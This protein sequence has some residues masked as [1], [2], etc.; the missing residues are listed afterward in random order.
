MYKKDRLNLILDILGKSKKISMKELRELTKFTDSTLRRDVIS[1]ENENKIQH[2]YGQVELVKARNVEFP[3][4]FRKQ[5][6]ETQ[7][8]AM[9]KIAQDFL[10]D[11]MAIFLDASSTVAELLPYLEQRKNLI[12]ITNGL[13]NASRLNHVQGVKTF[14]TG[15]QLRPGSGSL[16][17][18]FASGYL[19]NFTADIAFLSCSGV[20]TKAFYMPSEEQSAIKRT[21]MNLA[22]ETVMMC[23]SSKFNQTNYYKLCDLKE[24]NTLI[25]DKQPPE[26]LN[27]ALE[28]AGVEILY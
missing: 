25:T 9:A 23:D 5:E 8:Q 21:M 24:V 12:V 10:G 2:R 11:N 17:G 16:L 4:Q 18:E 14:L 27:T 28:T 22:K 1:L 20:D 19:T 26:D 3:F 7:K 6:M 15:G 13:Y